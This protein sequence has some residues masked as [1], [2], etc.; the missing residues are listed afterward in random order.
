MKIG[1]TGTRKGMSKD[2]KLAVK[3]IIAEILQ[4]YGETQYHHGDCIGADAE[5]HKIALTFRGNFP[6]IIHPSVDSQ[7][8]AFCESAYIMPKRSY[9][10]RNKDIVD[11]CDVLVAAPSSRKEELRSGTWATVRYARKKGK[12]IKFAY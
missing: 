5:F 3:E 10:D 1:F 7:A 9:L 8:R 2:Q 12:P 4:T 11:A 6:I